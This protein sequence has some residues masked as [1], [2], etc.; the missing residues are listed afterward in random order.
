L[1][2]AEK[3]YYANKLLQDKNNSRKVWQTIN[4][5]IGKSTHSPTIAEIELNGAKITDPSK[6]ADNFNHYFSNL[7]PS[8]ARSITPSLQRPAD[9]LQTSVADSIFLS[10]V[11]PSE[12]VDHIALMKNSTSKGYD[13]VALGVLKHTA[14]ELSGVL[15]Q[16]FNC[17][18]EQG[19]F[20]DQLKLAKVVPIFKS[21]DRLK[22]SNYR[23]ISILSPFAKLLEKLYNTRLISF[24][25]KNN[26]LVDNQYG[27]RKNLSTELALLDLTNQISKALD[28][29][30][31]MIGIFLDLSKAFDTVNHS[32]LIKKLEFYGIRG[33]ALNWIITYLSNRYQYVV[34]D[35]CCSSSLAVTCGVPQGSILGPLLFILYINDLCSATDVSLLMFADDTNMF[36]TGYCPITLAGSVNANLDKVSQWFSANLLSLNLSKTSYMIFSKKKLL[37][38]NFTISLGGEHLNRVTETKF[39]GLSLTED[40]KWGKQIDTVKISKVVGILYR[41]S[42]ILDTDKLKMLYCALLEPYIAYCC[43]VWGSPY[44]NGNLDRILRVQKRAVRV[45]TH[46]SY[47]AHSNPLFYSIK[48]L[49]IYDLSHLAVLLFV[50]RPIISSLVNSPLSLSLLI[51]STLITRGVLL[52]LMDETTAPSTVA[53]SGNATGPERH[54]IAEGYRLVVRLGRWNVCLMTTITLIL[55]PRPSR[56]LP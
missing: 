48:M 52:N 5:M 31:I 21:G 53:A 6:I 45:I 22:V 11:T 10:P 14:N 18:L 50:Y 46:S 37:N 4:K 26:I 40:L 16:V 49:T 15:A 44:K 55:T 42:H 33:A 35:G 20:P 34:V 17:S 29:Q 25:N 23:P 3:G 41:V 19:V 28:E 30:Q 51:R 13:D 9:Y 12:I 2:A 47:L 8:L 32:I 36:A 56:R 43:S 39:L 24:V 7:G 54:V 27:F 1:R 38:T